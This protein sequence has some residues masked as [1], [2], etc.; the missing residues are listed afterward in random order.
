MIEKENPNSLNALLE[1]YEKQKTIDA[2]ADWEQLR[3]RITSDRNRRLFFN[4]LRNTA[5]I[6]LPLFLVYQ[7]TLY[8]ILKK[9]GSIVE[10]ITVT[11]APGMVTKTILPDGSEVWLNALSSLTYPQRFTEKERRV[12]LSGEA[13]FKVTSDKKHRFNVE[14]P[15]KMVVS[16]YGTEFNVNAYENEATHE[17]TLASGHVEVSSEIG[18]KATE[19]LVVDEKAILQVKTG[20]IHVVTADT[21]VETAWKDG[22]MVFRREKLDK[23]ATRLSRKFGVDIRLEGNRLKGYEYT[24]TFTDETLEDILDLLKRSAPITYSISKQKQ[25]NNKTFTRREVI[26]KSK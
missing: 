23:I 4:Y 1:N 21:Y 25:L 8:P 20:N 17:V 5:A 22:K 7:Y 12:Q 14:T 6:L 15:Q 10:T 13:Y 9:S 2:A 19:T 16:A 18:S 11:S 26:I 3:K 24:A